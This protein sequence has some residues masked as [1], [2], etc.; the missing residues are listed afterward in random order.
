MKTFIKYFLTFLFGFFV[1]LGGLFVVILIAVSSMDY[2]QVSPEIAEKS[3]LK[4]ELP[5]ELSELSTEDPAR[6]LLAQIS[7]NTLNLGLNQLKDAIR[8]AATN[9]KIQ[10]I[11]LD[12]GSYNGG[13]A[14][15]QE[16]RDELLEFKKSKKWIIAYSENYSEQGYFIATSADKVYLNP[17]GM[18]EFDGFSSEI[19]FFKGLMEK[20]GIEF[21]VFK[22][23]KFKGAVEPYTEDKLS[24]ANRSQIQQ[25]L[26]DLY[27]HQIQQ[28]SKTRIT[29]NKL[30]N[31]EFLNRIS[32]EGLAFLPKQA[33]SIGLVDAL[34]YADE[35]E[36]E[37]QN[38]VPGNSLVSL[39]KY[40]KIESEYSYSENRIAVLYADGEI[41]AGEGEV[42]QIGS[43]SFIKEIRKIKDDKNIK[44]VVL[45]VNSPGGS[46]FASDVIAREIEL[47]KK[48]KPVVVS[49]SNVA[50]SGGYYI[51][52]LGDSIFAQPNSITGSI[53]VFA[54]IPNVQNMYTNK[55]G[56]KY[57][58]VQTGKE[59][60]LWRPDQPLN[61]AQ[62]MKIQASIDQVYT[63]FIEIVAKGRKLPK[64]SVHNLAQG[65]VYSGIRAKK[66]GLIDDFGDLSRAIQS[67][68]KMAKI[69][70][71][72]ID[73]YPE[74]KPLFEEWFEDE[75]GV[76]SSLNNYLNEI[77]IDKLTVKELKSIKNTQG[78]QCRMPWSIEIH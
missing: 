29:H 4:I 64:D 58:T 1:A 45:R 74:Q 3:V 47:L 5:S 69:K 49:F 43:T 67:A 28:I 75:L 77:G 26:N 33:E 56:L 27:Q 7:G 24:D 34:K 12:A 73:N 52:C 53:G 55:L 42:G 46:S 21:Q 60:N 50:A 9:P 25:Y 36:S 59:S 6:E 15:S 40:L 41:V 19:V 32:N 11:Y 78:I 70:E 20:L 30:L 39:K 76:E 66:I 13:I 37:I 65:R 57:E 72:R 2:E 71:Y 48:V 68:S 10:G 63:D 35:V 31:V 62:S 8:S 18:M 22:V 54:L 61:P 44:A 23:G 14:H 38:K 17:K 51:A 16:I